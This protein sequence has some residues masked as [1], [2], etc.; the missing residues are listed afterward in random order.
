MT[1]SSV[2]DEFLTIFTKK[3]INPSARE[4][5][6]ANPGA[7]AIIHVMRVFFV[8]SVHAERV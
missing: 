5:G 4:R 8:A 2:G 1:L 6:P 3:L 7:C